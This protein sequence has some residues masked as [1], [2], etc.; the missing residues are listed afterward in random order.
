MTDDSSLPDWISPPGSIISAILAINKIALDEFA[1]RLSISTRSARGVLEG[2]VQIDEPIAARLP[3]VVGSTSAFWL[4]CEATYQ[5]DR[6]RN[7]ASYVDE[8]V[9]SWMANLPIKEMAS[10]G[11]I[12]VE[13]DPV[14]QAAACFDFFGVTSLE[15]WKRRQATL[16]SEVNFRT[17]IAFSSNPNATSA[18]LRKAEGE[19]DDI[20][21][22]PWSAAAL[23]HRLEEMRALSRDRHPTRF[24]P[25]LRELCAECG[26]ALVLAPAP[27]G[28]RASGATRFVSGRKAMILLSFRYFA[29]DHFW[30]TFFHEAGH[31]LQHATEELFLEEDGGEVDDKEREANEFA[32]RTLIPPDK[33]GEMLDLAPRYADYIEFARE[34]GIAPGIVVGQMQRL[35]RLPYA[36]LNRLKRRLEWDA[37]YQQGLLNP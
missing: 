11:W 37:L 7:F 24:V 32:Q 6:R 8:E 12:R 15:D 21:C 23:E 13:K 28:C 14:E 29:D 33:V 25:R 19:A 22:E 2:T 10:W 18:W 35:G 20:R 16:L 9:T 27:Q 4:R 36:W 3:E 17:S 5:A 30:F 1:Q 31:L 26:V 34:I